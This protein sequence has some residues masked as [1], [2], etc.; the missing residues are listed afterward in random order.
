MDTPHPVFQLLALG[1]PLTLLV[2][3]AAPLGPDSPGIAASES[4]LS[5]AS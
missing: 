5:W 3:L 2:D 1:V 4:E